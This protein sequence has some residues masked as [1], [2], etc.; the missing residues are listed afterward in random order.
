MLFVKISIFRKY[1]IML[2]WHIF[3]RRRLDQIA[4]PFWWQL[5]F[6]FRIFASF[7]VRMCWLV[8]F[9]L[10]SMTMRFSWSQSRAPGMQSFDAGSLC[11]PLNLWDCANVAISHGLIWEFDSFHLCDRWRLKI[12][13]KCTFAH[14]QTNPWPTHLHPFACFHLRSR[15]LNLLA[16]DVKAVHC[17]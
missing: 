15:Q 9:R 7:Q 14:Q 6:G 2:A 3:M 11:N 17:G 1:N 4:W 5:C 10:W 8:G 12:F 13:W 16:V